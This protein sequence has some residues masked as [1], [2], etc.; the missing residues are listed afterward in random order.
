MGTASLGYP[1]GPSVTFR[2]SRLHKNIMCGITAHG[3]CTFPGCTNTIK[4]RKLCG[5]HYERQRRHGNPETVLKQGAKPGKTGE[6]S[7]QW[8]GADA[9]LDAQHKRISSVRGTPKLCTNC[10]TTDPEKHYHW[11]FNNTGDRLNIW[12]YIRLCAGCHRLLDDAFT[13]RGSK[14]GGAKLT[15]ADIPKIFEMRRDDKKLREI[16]EAFSISTTQASDILSGKN[17]GHMKGG[18]A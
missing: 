2:S 10:G 9:G 5:T 1:G 17:W 15:E 14:H 3:P 12:D 4:A 7:S 6:L 18:G 11:A 8:K 16:G 13:P